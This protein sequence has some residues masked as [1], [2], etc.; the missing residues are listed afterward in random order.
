M[1]VQLSAVRG[2]GRGKNR[3][4]WRNM[5]AGL[6]AAGRGA[7]G[8]EVDDAA[9]LLWNGSWELGLEDLAR[10]YASGCGQWRG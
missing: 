2:V 1:A 9:S 8:A 10:K 6:D 7:G 5:V 4:Y 3:P